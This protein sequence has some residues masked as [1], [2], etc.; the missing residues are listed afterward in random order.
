MNSL[1]QEVIGIIIIAV[2]IAVILM[3]FAPKINPEPVEGQTACFATEDLK[4]LFLNHSTDTQYKI[5][6]PCKE[7]NRSAIPEDESGK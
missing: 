4:K 2:I 3:A 7:L 1:T 5:L 6:G